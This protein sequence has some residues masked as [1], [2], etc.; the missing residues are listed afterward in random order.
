MNKNR[1]L[2]GNWKLKKKFFYYIILVEV[3][4]TSYIRWEKATKEDIMILRID[5]A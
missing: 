5:V 1:I 2:T 4:G 3:I